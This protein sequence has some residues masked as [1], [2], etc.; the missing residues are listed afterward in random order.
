MWEFSVNHLPGDSRAWVLW[1]VA[2]YE[3]AWKSP[4]LEDSV[5]LRARRQRNLGVVGWL[6]LAGLLKV[7]KGAAWVLW[8]VEYFISMNVWALRAFLRL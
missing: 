4:A 7:A 5:R 3:R 8:E 1:P 2:V 6:G